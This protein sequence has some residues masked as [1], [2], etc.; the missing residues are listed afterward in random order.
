MLDNALGRAREAAARLSD[1]NATA[2]DIESARKLANDIAKLLTTAPEERERV[3]NEYKVIILGE[4]S[5]ENFNANGLRDALGQYA[6]LR[7]WSG[8]DSYGTASPVTVIDLFIKNNPELDAHDIANL[9]AARLR[10]SAPTQGG[11]G[12]GVGPAPPAETPPA[13]PPQSQ[14]PIRGGRLFSRQNT[15]ALIGWIRAGI[16][17]VTPADQLAAHRFEAALSEWIQAQLNDFN[18]AQR[19][20]DVHHT[21]TVNEFLKAVHKCAVGTFGEATADA[22]D[23][24][25]RRVIDGGDLTQNHPN[26]TQDP[27][28][29]IANGSDLMLLQVTF[30]LLARSQPRPPSGGAP[31]APAPGPSNPPPPA[32][33]PGG[34]GTAPSQPPG[35]SAAETAIEHVRRLDALRRECVQARRELDEATNDEEAR[36]LADRLSTASSAYRNAL[37]SAEL[38]SEQL[39]RDII[40]LARNHLNTGV[41]NSGPLD[42]A[43]MAYAQLGAHLDGTAEPTSVSEG[44]AR[45][46]QRLGETIAWGESRPDLSPE[47]RADLA[48]LEKVMNFLVDNAVNELAREHAQPGAGSHEP[49]ADAPIPTSEDIARLQRA[50]EDAEAAYDKAEKERAKPEELFRLA[51]KIGD[52]MIELSDAGQRLRRARGQQPSAPSEAPPAPP[53][54]TEP[55]DSA[56]H[57]R[58][59][60]QGEL[61]DLRRSMEDAKADYEK[62]ERDHA[63]KNVTDALLRKW[64]GARNRLHKAQQ[65]VEA[66]AAQRQADA[67]LDF[68]DKI[69]DLAIRV[70]NGG[71]QDRVALKEA[72]I[73]FDTMTGATRGQVSR[74]ATKLAGVIGRLID[75]ANASDPPPTPAQ[76]QDLSVLR[77]VQLFLVDIVASEIATEQSGQNAPRQEP[78][79][80]QPVEGEDDPDVN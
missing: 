56:P 41:D 52:A 54:G 22:L 37:Q 4:A 32:P 78:V 49:P 14:S 45:M 36:G 55:P 62:A 9:R 7:G 42:A 17:Y 80:S 3:L 74:G 13:A 47:A 1:V 51:N 31:P 72:L 70:I 10:L 30:D 23:Q 5:P 11:P 20:G 38:E 77:R 15:R 71:G 76:R 40:D 29:L 25:L 6:I 73:T 61:D 69:I 65:R 79:E 53:S 60:T 33:P 57:E 28:L 24:T 8:G 27:D 64:I 68:G 34:P 35:P 63:P 44:A 46:A 18:D 58:V 16:P 43:L 66:A 21:V 59:P 48:D 39:A 26:L 50:I 12:G 2:S 75:R 67:A 19:I